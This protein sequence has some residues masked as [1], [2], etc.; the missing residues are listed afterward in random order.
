MSHPLR[1]TCTPTSPIAGQKPGTSGLRKKTAVFTAGLYL[2]N[3]VQSIF[4]ALPAGE[5]RGST[6]VVSGDG[7][8][9]CKEATQVILKIAAA[10]GVARVWVGKDGASSCVCGVGRAASSSLSQ[11]RAQSASSPHMCA[12]P[13]SVQPSSQRL[14]CPR[15]S[16]SARAAA[17]MAA[18]C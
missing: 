15:S 8:Y 3:F 12:L 5:L 4:D 17:R 16:A 10:N 1:V 14:P 11:L 7:R 2:H 6:L 18:S 13:H 9:F